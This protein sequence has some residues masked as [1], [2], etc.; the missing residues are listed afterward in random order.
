MK[1]LMIIAAVAAVAAG[2]CSTEIT[3]EKNGKGEVKYS[4]ERK[5]HWLK[6]SATGIRGG[7][8]HDGDFDFSAEG[9]EKSP[10][11]EFNRTMQTYTSA[12]VSMM[13]IAAAAYNP[14]STGVAAAKATGPTQ[15]VVNVQ[16]PAATTNAV[17]AAAT[18]SEAK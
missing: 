15:T 11:E 18:T 12:I 4:L 5:D 14:S 17:S 13:Q 2:C 10:S 7:M 1:K 6:T 3:Y 9:M 16:V 8:S